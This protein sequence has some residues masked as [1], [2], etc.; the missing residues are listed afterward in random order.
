MEV[1]RADEADL[2]RASSDVFET[3]VRKRTGFTEDLPDGMS[4]SVNE[5][6]FAP[7]E[8]TNFHDHSIRQVLYVVSGKGVLATEDER[9]E[10][11]AG[12]IISIPP[13]EAHWHGATDDDEF[14][15]LSIVV[16]DPESGGTT[17][18]PDIPLPDE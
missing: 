11:S 10:V 15:H 16:R 9:H 12:D 5:V 13:D 4:L 2:E 1:N 3:S 18:L 6:V 7:G 8:R 14:R 17:A